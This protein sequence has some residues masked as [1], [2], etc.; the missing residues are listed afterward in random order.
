MISRIE[1][2]QDEEMVDY[3]SGKKEFL[4]VSPVSIKV[5]MGDEELELGPRKLFEILRVMINRNMLRFRVRMPNEEYR[6]VYTIG[7]KDQLQQVQ[8][9]DCMPS[10]LC[11]L[12]SVGEGGED[13]WDWD[14]TDCLLVNNFDTRRVEICTTPL[15]TGLK[16][17][18]VKK[19]A[20]KKGK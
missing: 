5:K 6:R 2:E 13:G 7:W 17:T 8:T 15:L 11:L 9:L 19:D 16:A 1:C 20:K 18:K 12:E 3:E 14:D 4:A 10:D